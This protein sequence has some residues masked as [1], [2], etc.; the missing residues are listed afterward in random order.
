[1]LSL[2]SYVPGLASSNGVMLQLYFKRN[3]SAVLSSSCNIKGNGFFFFPLPP[4]PFFARSCIGLM[5]F[6]S[7]YDRRETRRENPA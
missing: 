2:R 5:K 4:P 1:M 3:L 7:Q 6:P